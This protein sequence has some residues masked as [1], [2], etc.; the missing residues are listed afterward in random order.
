VLQQQLPA[1]PARQQRVPVP[2]HDRTATSTGTVRSGPPTSPSAPAVP[3]GAFACS[4]DT[5]PHSAH[6]VTPKDAFS[7]LHPVT[8]RP[9]AASPA[10]PTRSREYGAYAR[11]AASLA[12]ARSPAHSMIIYQRCATR[13]PQATG[14]PG[15]G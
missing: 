3:D 12:A 1:P 6:S 2:R 10:A 8:I 4:A 5:S 14:G 7:T 13:S 15:A 11:A 9:P